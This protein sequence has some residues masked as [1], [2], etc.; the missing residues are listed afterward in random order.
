[1][2]KREL[3]EAQISRSMKR[4]MELPPPQLELSR[5][6]ATNMLA[7]VGIGLG[8]LVLMASVLTVSLVLH[9]RPTRGAQ[10]VAPASPTAAA[11]PEA[12]KAV[13]TGTVS[14]PVVYPG[15]GTQLDPPGILV[16]SLSAVTAVDSC[17]L[18]Q[19]HVICEL[20][21]PASIELGLLR[22]AGMQ[23][24]GELVW[25]MTWTSVSCD[26]MGPYNRPTL[27][28]K[29]NGATGCDFV[30]FVDA[31]TGGNPEAIRG[32]FGL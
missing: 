11:S 3:D 2:T 8:T 1:M 7:A 25:A 18:P 6:R 15:T 13:V 30:S 24:N 12:N 20:G 19:A 5:R 31:N 17:S 28:P 26:V 14:A 29:V 9:N 32:A 23:I 22:D 4:L 21:H 10:T 27:N 16:P